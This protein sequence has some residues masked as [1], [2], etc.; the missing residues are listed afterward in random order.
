MILIHCDV[1]D[2]QLTKQEIN[3]SHLL[4]CTP[5]KFDSAT[6]KGGDGSLM[7]MVSL[8]IIDEIHLLADERGDKYI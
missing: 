8:I 2:M 4:V 5:E 3:D 6:R 7:T 1:G